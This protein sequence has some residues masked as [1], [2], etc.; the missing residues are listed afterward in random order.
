M[1]FAEVL[2]QKIRRQIE[3]EMQQSPPRYD[4][5]R[6]S[7]APKLSSMETSLLWSLNLGPVLFK[8]QHQGQAYHRQRKP[9]PAHV[10]N[11][12]QQ[13]AWQFFQEHQADLA[14]NFNIAELKAAFRHL[15]L[16]L[17]PDHGGS[18]ELF[19]ALYQARKSLQGLVSKASA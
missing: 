9:R 8:S 7:A 6:P 5:A 10:M 4:G 19:R 3:Q 17:H 13:S 16:K 11:K 14:D 15:A 2:E 12:G 1:N 18:N